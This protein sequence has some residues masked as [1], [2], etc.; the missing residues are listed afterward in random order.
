M[1][2]VTDNDAPFVKATSYIAKKYQLCHIHISGYNLHANGLVERPH[3]NVRQAL[4]KVVDGE[5][6]RW[7]QAAYS[8]F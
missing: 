2:I 6:S 7:S 8:V 5:E 4:F 3:F 1:K